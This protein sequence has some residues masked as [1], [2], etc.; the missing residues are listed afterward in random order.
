MP[1][2]RTRAP[3]GAKKAA[4]RPPNGAILILRIP[5]NLR[6]RAAERA[7]LHHVS[8]SEAVRN[9][10]ELWLASFGNDRV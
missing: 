10:L 7:A 8:L 9:A 3:K 1:E 4:D 5:E 2:P 6:E